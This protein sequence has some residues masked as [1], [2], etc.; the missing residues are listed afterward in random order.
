M[1]RVA[2]SKYHGLGNDFVIIDA[3]DSGDLMTSDRARV[4]CDRNRGIGADGVLTLLPSRTDHAQLR[5]HIW[6]ADGSVAQMC[7]NGLRCVV[8]F[9]QKPEVLID[10]DGGLRSGRLLEDGRVRVSLG[11]PAFTADTLQLSVAGHDFRGLQ[12]DMGNPHY[13]LEVHED[14]EALRGMAESFGAA[15]E[16]HSAFPDRSNIEFLSWN[17]GRLVVVVH[18][19]GVGITQACGSGAGASYVAVKHWGL[20]EADASLTVELLGG[21]LEVDE[22]DGEIFIT[23]DAIEVFRGQ[24]A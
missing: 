9:L 19:R 1:T 2:F 21:A 3:R 15:L 22:V 18:E 8:A 7:G 12:V 23:G 20:L 14:P 13:V 10:T 4:L 24:L 16:R 11:K 6:N 17:K 5:M